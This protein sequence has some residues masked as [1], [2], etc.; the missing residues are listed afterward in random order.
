MG[1]PPPAGKRA[2]SILAMGPGC[3][4]DLGISSAAAFYVVTDGPPRLWGQERTDHSDS[5]TL[6]R[7]RVLIPDTFCW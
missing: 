3:R 6:S 2:Q 7:V 4:A 1:P 5:Q